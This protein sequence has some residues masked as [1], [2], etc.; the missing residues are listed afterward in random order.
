MLYLIL[1]SC[2]CIF[3]VYF[4]FFITRFS[5][6]CLPIYYAHVCSHHFH[7]YCKK[8]KASIFIPFQPFTSLIHWSAVTRMTYQI[9]L[10]LYLKN[11]HFFQISCRVRSQPLIFLKTFFFGNMDHFLKSLLNLLHYCLCCLC[12]GFLAMKHVGYSFPDQGLN[13][14][15]VHWKIKS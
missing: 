12:S 4:L 7:E 1:L 13:T 11:I 9:I 3:Q 15:P 2:S 6:D 10:P 14:H 5:H 8:F